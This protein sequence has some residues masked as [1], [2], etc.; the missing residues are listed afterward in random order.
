M[1]SDD[2]KQSLRKARRQAR[3]RSSALHRS[4]VHFC[5]P[6]RANAPQ[7][8]PRRGVNKAFS[9]SCRISAPAPRNH[10]DRQMFANGV[11]NHSAFT[12]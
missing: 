6:L 1:L 3:A 8:G 12:L 7:F 10:A 5:Q 9:E 2:T 11:Q 4:P